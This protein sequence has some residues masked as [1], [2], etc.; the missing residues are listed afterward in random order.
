M[1]VRHRLLLLEIITGRTIIGPARVNIS[2][3]VLNSTVRNDLRGQN[4]SANS[5]RRHRIAIVCIVQKSSVSQKLERLECC[6]RRSFH[7]SN[8]VDSYFKRDTFIKHS[9]RRSMNVY[10]QWSM[11]STRWRNKAIFKRFDT[12]IVSRNKGEENSIEKLM[13]ISSFENRATTIHGRRE[14]RWIFID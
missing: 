2:R 13:L 12:T 7:I 5:V 14:R 11:P 3:F 10:D 8:N 4:S 6:S 9:E 1:L